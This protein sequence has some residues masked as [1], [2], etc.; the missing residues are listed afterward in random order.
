MAEYRAGLAADGRRHDDFR[1]AV[2]ES[3]RGASARSAYQAG[4][5]LQVVALARRQFTLKL[6]DRFNLTLAWMRSI[7]IAL[8]LGS[9]YLDLGR[10]SASAFSKGGLLFVTLFFNA[11]QALSELAGTILGRAIVNKHKAYAFHR[12]SALCIAQILVD[13]AFAVTEVSG[14]RHRLLHDGPRPRRRRL[15][16]LLPAHPLGQCRHEARLPHHRLPQ[17]RL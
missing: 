1:T 11:F 7:V 16:H 6:Q 4:F 12:P 9:L 3:K 8:V 17:S 13:K 2:R 14:L 5:H 10:T 15:L